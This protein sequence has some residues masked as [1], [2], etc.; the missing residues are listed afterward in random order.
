MK[1]DPT[2]DFHEQL[3]KLRKRVAEAQPSHH[4]DDAPASPAKSTKN[5]EKDATNQDSTANEPETFSNLLAQ[6]MSGT[7][8]K[9][10]ADNNQHPHFDNTP[11]PG[12]NQRR[13]AIA[14]LQSE[15]EPAWLGDETE[16]PEAMLTWG[17]SISY[18]KSG[19][20]NGYIKKLRRGQ[21]R[22]DFTIDLHGYYLREATQTVHKL[23]NVAKDNH[24]AAVRIIHGK[25]KHSSNK[26]PVIKTMLNHQLRLRDDV[27]AFCTAPQH[28]G[29]T[30]VLYCLLQC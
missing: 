5:A 13:H 26:G 22:I 24:H 11:P 2:T 23:L 1:N 8:I 4:K 3:K 19:Y 12:K 20:P 27:I 28:D 29:G 9:P 6:S 30:G 18:I 7:P 14:P 25:G 21:Y 10:L 17:E 16:I 15:S